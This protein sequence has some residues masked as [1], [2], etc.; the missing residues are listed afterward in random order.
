MFL[1]LSD[2]R[3]DFMSCFEPVQGFRCAVPTKNGK[4]G[5]TLSKDYARRVRVNGVYEYE[6]MSVNCH[7]C[8][9]CR[10]DR[11]REWAVKICHEAQ[12]NCVDGLDNNAFITLTYNDDPR[13]MPLYGALDYKKH[14]TKFLKRLRKRVF[15]Q[16]G[17]RFR[18]FMVGEYG[19]LNLRPHYHAIIFGFNFPDKYDYMDRYGHV[20]SRSKLLEDCWTNPDTH[21]SYGYSSVGS[22]SYL[23]A[24]Y[25]A[26]YNFKKLI[27]TEFDGF[28]ECVHVDMDG[29]VTEFT[30][31]ILSRRYVRVD[32]ITGQD[33]YVP[34]ERNFQSNGGGGTG[35]GGIG[36]KWFDQYAMTDMFSLVGNG[37]D[38]VIKD[39]THL[40][41]GMLV[42]PP[43]Y[44]DKLLE[45]INPEL[46]QSVRLA[47][48][49]HRAAHVDDL[50]EDRLRQKEIVLLDK[51]KFKK[52]NIGDVYT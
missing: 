21:L 32:P 51:L 34:P 16:Y 39:H 31:P 17:V 22:V 15:Q 11:S 38:F 46:M 33:V 10:Y 7:K 35:K 47:R 26:R 9:G 37:V 6:V 4:Y 2:G 40:D 45:S 42:R 43:K 8:V 5:F 41:N 3:I 48:Q 19:S 14:W 24:A 27:G 36:R 20:L 50:T 1:C 52:R 12:I 28:E 13:N 29:V 30:R 23:S 49:D 44:Y 25:V 18:F